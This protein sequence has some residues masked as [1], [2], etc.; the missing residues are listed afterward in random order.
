MSRLG[1]LDIYQDYKHEG[2]EYGCCI[3]EEISNIS[4]VQKVPQIVNMTVNEINAPSAESAADVKLDIT[5]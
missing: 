1:D 2:Q 4:T 5:H 3:F